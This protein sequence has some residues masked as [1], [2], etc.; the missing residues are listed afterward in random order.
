MKLYIPEYSSGDVEGEGFRPLAGVEHEAGHAVEVRPHRRVHDRKVVADAL[1]EAEDPVLADDRVERGAPLATAVAVEDGAVGE[2]AGE[3]GD[4]TAPVVIL[5]T[6]GTLSWPPDMCSKVAA[7]FR[8]WSSA[9]RLKLT[10]MIS[11]MGLI[12]ASAAPIP[13]PTKADSD[14]GASR[15]RS[16]PNS[17]SRPRVTP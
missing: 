4:G 9:S 13:A 8:I 7:L 12:P 14:R 6:R 5:M 3:E 16:G 15:I 11:T 17:S 10:V 2:G 1:V